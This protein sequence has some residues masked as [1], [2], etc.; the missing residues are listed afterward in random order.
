MSHLQAENRYARGTL[1]HLRPSMGELLFEMRRRVAEN[2][3]GVPVAKNGMFYQSC[4]N[5]GRQYPVHL[6]RTGLKQRKE[7]VLLDLNERA[8]G[9]RYYALGS[10]VVSPD[11]RLLAWTEDRVGQR[12]YELHIKEIASGQELVTPVTD[13]DASLAWSDDSLLYVAK[14]PR[15][16]LGNRVMRHRLGGAVADTVVY[17]E[18]D[19]R[20]FLNVRRSRSERFVMIGSSSTESTE[21]RYARSDD[22]SLGF[23]LV[24]PR[25]SG[26]EYEAEDHGN[27]WVVLSN[28]Q[29]DNFRLLRTP[30]STS[31]DRNTWR[32]WLAHDP[33]HLLESM[34][35]L[36]DAVII[37]ERHNGLRRLRVKSW[38]D[39]QERTI[40][41]PDSSYVATANANPVFATSTFRLSYSSLATPTSIYE[42]DLASGELEL[43][44]REPVLGKFRPTNYVS[45]LIF[46]PARDGQRIP[47]SLLYRKRVGARA[48]SPMLI[49][50]YGAY[51][52]S[53]DPY[54][55]SSR[56]SMVD[57]GVLI[58]IAHVRGGEEMGRSWYQQGRHLSKMNTFTDFIDATDH[59][60]SE[61][62]ADPTRVVAQGGSAGGLLV[63]AVANMAPDRYRAIIAHAPFVDVVTSMLDAN[64]PLTSNEYGEWGN[65]DYKTDY[66]YMLR[67][68]PYDNVRAQKY[69]AMM[70]STG[71]FD[72]QVPYWEPAKWVAKLR[73][74]NQSDAPITLMSNLYA[75]HS[76]SSGRYRRFK[77]QALNQ[78]YVLDQMGIKVHIT[79]K[80]HVNWPKRTVDG[81]FF[82]RSR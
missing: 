37:A 45:E 2:D 14:D 28:W 32:E 31:T 80:R 71:I 9:L 74:M 44:K 5:E 66:E 16:M 7:Q 11:N 68:S 49:T 47:V 25:E 65:P 60:V 78:A 73:T 17:T 19:N 35:V 76:G 82:V 75:G 24:Y 21:W 63:A 30:I 64:L 23:Q 59:L 18:P 51:G 53:S 12:R 36:R 34:T 41:F 57:R 22:P 13:V 48:K 4:F 39:G 54:F 61:G 50:G 72:T 20:Y 69:P 26:H 33:A 27:E 55:N 40:T 46:V 70:V 1:D 38:A 6:R 42:Y 62:W 15:T 79:R 10:M 8:N 58:A 3:C 52:N 81:E 77:E 43:L 67:Y 29:A 56:L